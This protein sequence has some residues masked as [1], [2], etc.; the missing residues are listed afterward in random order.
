MDSLRSILAVAL[1]FGVFVVGSM[2][3]RGAST[4]H[5]GT[6]PTAGLVA[7]AIAY[8]VV[9]AALGGLTAASV[10]GRKPLTHAL[11]LAG[12]IAA[13]AL[14]HPW[15]DPGSSPRWLDLA[16]VL[17]MA[18]AAVFAGWARSRLPAH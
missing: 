12:L 11:V 1:G 7:G 14:A 17:L 4:E 5:P 13:A 16:A 8:G 15:F 9:F 3:P 10:A 2:L 6:P 18:P